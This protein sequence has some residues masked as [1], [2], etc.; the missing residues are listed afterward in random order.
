VSSQV[1]CRS[2]DKGT[3]SAGS[4]NTG[5]PTGST[6]RWWREIACEQFALEM[7][8]NEMLEILAIVA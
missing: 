5:S 7:T 3:I 1:K 6:V 2:A 4:D 8:A